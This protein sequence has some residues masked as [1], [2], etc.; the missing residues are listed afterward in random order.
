MTKLLTICRKIYLVSPEDGEYKEF[1]SD[2]WTTTTAAALIPSTQKVY[3]TTSF[4]NLW[5]ISL[6]EREARKISWDGWGTCNALVAVPN[7]EGGHKLFAFCHKLW[8]VDDPDKGHCVDF[9]G[10][11]TDVWTRVNA[12]AVVG[13]HIFAT[14]SAN[15]LWRIDSTGHEEPKKLGGGSD[16]WS[17]CRALVEV[18]GKLIAFC[19]GLWEVNIHNGDSTPF[20][21]DGSDDAKRSWSNIKSATVI[22]HNIYVIAGSQLLELDTII[23]KVREVN[24][25]NW[26]FTKAI[27]AVE[28]SQFD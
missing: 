19:Y 24:N 6:N 4:N 10:R 17:T 28:I 14:T 3:I 8:L 12:A 21:D 13:Y 1:N 20:F 23:K 27:V 25:E 9:L 11:F 2:D 22:G 15:N 7:D 16:N 5:E 26:E 18:D